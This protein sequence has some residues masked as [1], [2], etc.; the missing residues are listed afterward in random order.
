MRDVLRDRRQE[1]RRPHLVFA[2]DT[3]SPTP[4]CARRSPQPP[5]LAEEYG[6]GKGDRVAIA[7]ANTVEYPLTIW[8]VH[9]NSARSSPAS[10]AGGPVPSSRTAWSSRQPKVLIGDEPRL[11]RI[12]E[13]RRGDRRARRARGTSSRAVGRG[14]AARPRCP[15]RRS[16][17]TTRSSSCSRAARPGARRA[18]RCRTATSSTSRSAAGCAAR[19]RDA[20]RRTRTGT[21]ASP[22]AAGVD[23]APARS[24]TSRASRRS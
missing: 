8:A 5:R 11:E 16:T 4:R 24:S 20:R 18:R 10:T 22:M 6:V 23:C 2:D 13:S 1:L 14:A 3:S 19:R 12:A 9:R 7:S 17:R 21:A 15:T